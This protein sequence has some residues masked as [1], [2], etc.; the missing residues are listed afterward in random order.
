MDEEIMTPAEEVILSEEEPTPAPVEEEPAPVEEELAPAPVEE[1]VVEVEEEPAPAEAPA[2]VEERYALLEAENAEL[3]GKLS[4]LELK[5]SELTSQYEELVAFKTSIEEAEK[6]EMIEKFTMLSDEDKAD[7]IKNK[8]NYTLEEIESKL[9][10]I[11][12]RKKVKFDLA[13]NDNFNN[14]KSGKDLI[15]SFEESQIDN[16]PAWIQAVKNKR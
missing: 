14:K 6:D 9:S 11:C 12:V 16:A 13:D 3:K 4:D 1:E 15:Y 8:S 5:F 2:E 7:V 10:V